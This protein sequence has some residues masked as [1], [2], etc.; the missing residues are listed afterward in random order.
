MRHNGGH[1]EHVAALLHEFAKHHLH[2][3]VA[4]DVIDKML[5]HAEAVSEA[6]KNEQQHSYK[7]ATKLQ[8][9]G[10]H[11]LQNRFNLQK[12]GYTSEE[13]Q[14]F[15]GNVDPEDYLGM[16]KKNREEMER[17]L[18]RLIHVAT[19]DADHSQAKSNAKHKMR[20]LMR[21]L[22]LPHDIMGKRAVK[23]IKDFL[24]IWKAKHDC[25]RR[26]ND[27]AQVVHIEGT[28][29]EMIEKKEW[30]II[31]PRQRGEELLGVY[32]I[33]L[34]HNHPDPSWVN[35]PWFAELFGFKHAEDH[36][37]NGK[38]IFHHLFTSMQYCWVATAVAVQCFSPDQPHLPGNYRAAMCNMVSGHKPNGWTPLHCLCHASDTMLAK[39]M[40]IKALLDYNVVTVEDLYSLHTATPEV[41][42]FSPFRAMHHNAYVFLCAPHGARVFT[43]VHRIL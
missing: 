30:I 29:A 2:S 33:N 20:L 12:L 14:W 42:V 41:I 24:A 34:W 11:T 18:S 39:N 5:H 25:D 26:S 23:F 7:D 37:E 15:V 8:V 19:T 28:F 40:V 1:G 9:M 6:I 13:Q 4:N 35:L 16:V 10:Y 3:V 22:R 27:K 32:C 31:P 36:D 38:N 17:F 43:V 21:L